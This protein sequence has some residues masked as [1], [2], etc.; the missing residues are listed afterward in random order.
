MMSSRAAERAS[1]VDVSLVLAC[2]NE[3]NVLA[4]SVRCILD[5]LDGCR[6]SYELIFVD[7]CSRDDTAEQ[8]RRLVAEHPDHELRAIFHER[9]RGRGYTVAEGM[10]AGRGAIVGYIDVDLEIHARYVPSCIRAVEQGA[11]VA[12]GLRTHRFSW[13]SLDRYVLSRG[14]S[15]LMRRLLRVDLRDTETGFKF[16]RK[17]RILPVFDA[18]EDPHWFWDTEVMV[19]AL[20]G[21]LEIEEIPVLFVRRFDKQSSIRMVRDTIDY[22]VRLWRFRRTVSKL[23]REARLGGTERDWV[24]QGL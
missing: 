21:G 13:R 1:P 11:D 8:V 14:Y 18:I 9:N 20:L 10:R 17:D 6:W 2:F 7:D 24:R 5:T 23:H 16:F 3:G 15:T 22:F 12:T 4:D 19:R